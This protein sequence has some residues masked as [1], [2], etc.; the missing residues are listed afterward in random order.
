MRISQLI[1]LQL[2]WITSDFTFAPLPAV[3]AYALI[4][5]L[6]AWAAVVTVG[7]LIIFQ[8]IFLAELQRIPLAWSVLLHAVLV[9]ALIGSLILGHHW[10]MPTL[11]GT[12]VAHLTLSI[13]GGA[14]C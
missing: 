3:Y 14:P 4:P 5:L 7:V 13:S 12:P 8:A 6:C 1:L 9:V 2:G 10:Q 11:P